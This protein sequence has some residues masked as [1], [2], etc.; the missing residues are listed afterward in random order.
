MDSS[1]LTLIV[2]ILQEVV[3]AGEE[4]VVVLPVQVVQLALAERLASEAVGEVVWNCASGRFGPVGY[5]CP[6]TYWLWR[7]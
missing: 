3:M 5:F 7:E 6:R 1:A 4:I 2:G